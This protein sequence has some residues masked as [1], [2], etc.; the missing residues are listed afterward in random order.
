MTIHL[1]C[2]HKKKCLKLDELIIHG[3]FIWRRISIVYCSREVHEQFQK[4]I[5]QSILQ[6]LLLLSI[7]VCFLCAVL[8]FLRLFRFIAKVVAKAPAL[9]YN[10]QFVWPTKSGKDCWRF[11]YTLFLFKVCIWISLRKNKLKTGLSRRRA[12]V[13]WANGKQIKLTA[14]NIQG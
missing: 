6:H 4:W 1:E 2:M 12:V 9:K 13:V 11:F 8:F 14:N 10:L 7:K 3:L 5:L